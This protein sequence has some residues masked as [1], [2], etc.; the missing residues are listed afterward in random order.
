MAITGS[1]L[2]AMV[3]LGRNPDDCWIWLGNKNDAGYG[4]KQ[5]NGQT[6]LAHRWMWIVLF[7]PIP[8]GLVVKHKCT[9][10]D[11]VN[12]HH[13][14]ATTQADAC[15]SGVQTTLTPADVVE[16]KAARK[17]RGLNTSAA[18]ATRYGVSPNTIKSIWQGKSWAKPKPFHG[19]D[20]R[21]K[22]A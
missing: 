8:I 19:V 3:K 4:Q 20:S 9:N 22:E 14:M 5:F 13:L 2:K 7:G 6:L 18:L 21:S 12:P 15:R 16:I 10:R 1:T 17:T 11:C